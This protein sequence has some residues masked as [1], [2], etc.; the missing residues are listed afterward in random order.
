M[1]VIVPTK[2]SAEFLEACLVSIKNQSYCP[3]PLPA[4]R[5]LGVGGKKGES[6]G[7]FKNPHIELI[8]VDN[9]STDAT[10]YDFSIV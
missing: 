9:N 10:F 7:D 3:P 8:V 6:E 5:S 4:R 1:S 2:N